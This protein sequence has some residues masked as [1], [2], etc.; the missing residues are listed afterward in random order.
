ME[1]YSYERAISSNGKVQRGDMDRLGHGH[2]GRGNEFRVLDVGSDPLH[3][4]L[5]LLC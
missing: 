1:S 4:V 3:F 5:D 2:H